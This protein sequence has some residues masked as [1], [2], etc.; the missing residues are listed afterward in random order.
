[1]S[2]DPS[3]DAGEAERDHRVGAT[4]RVAFALREQRDKGAVRSEQKPG[5]YVLWQ[6]RR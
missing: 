6:L 2:P 3:R 5:Q 4:K 1:M